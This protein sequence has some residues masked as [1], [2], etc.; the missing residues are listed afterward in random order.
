MSQ[1]EES[2]LRQ[3][4]FLLIDRNIGNKYKITRIINKYLKCL[5]SS[6]GD[7]NKKIETSALSLL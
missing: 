2:K 5:E 7:E 4:L 1:A 3:E 6:G